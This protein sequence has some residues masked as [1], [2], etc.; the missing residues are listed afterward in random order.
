M[1]H[2]KIV[3]L[4]GRFPPVYGGGGNVEIS[5]GKELVKRGHEV[6]FITPR[7]KRVHPKTEVYQG[8]KVI[9][10]Y[11]PLKGP[12]SEM[13]YVLNSFLKMILTGIHPD[14]IVDCIPYGNSMII[15]NIFSKM[16]KVPVIARLTQT[17]ANEPSS[18][19]TSK[20][21]WI[22]KKYFSMY[23]S[24]MAISPDLVSNCLKAGI[25]CERVQLIPDCVDT[26]KFSPV[27]PEEKRKLKGRLFPDLQGLVV[28]IVGNVSKRKRSHLAVEAWKILL[29]TYHEP[30]KL[31]F[32]GPTKSSGHPFDEEYVERLRATILNYGLDDSVLLTGFKE[33]V[34]E[35]YQAADLTLFVSEREGLP[36]VVLQSMSSGVPVVTTNIENISEYM[37]TNGREGLITSDDPNEISQAMVTLLSDADLRDTMGKNARQN[38]VERFSIER[39]T[40]MV[41]E[42]FFSITMEKHK[43]K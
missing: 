37:L 26:A 39:N 12:I 8:I 28:L 33:N 6:L 16:L 32:V 29:S 23:Q 10:V 35:Y 2:L 41:E 5:R 18:S 21:G 27:S 42:L 3:D 38:V 30:A 31:V 25:K 9:R 4:I 24:T 40:D 11:P 22:R 17:G 36:G 20:F 34:H 19:E 15:T 14:V 1:K 43:I 7:Y 13:F